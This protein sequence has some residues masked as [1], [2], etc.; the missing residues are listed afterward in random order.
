MH[1]QE[2]VSL[3]G[4]TT[5]RIGGIARWYADL[6]TR[7]DVTKAVTFAE[8]EKVPLIILGGGSNTIFADGMINALVARLACDAVIMKDNI[9]T[10]EAAKNLPMLINELAVQ[11]LDLSALTGILG[12]V[13]GAVFGNAG[14]GPKGIWID[15]YIESVT[16][17]M[18]GI[19]RTPS[20]EQCNFRYRESWFKDQLPASPAGGSTL[21]SPAF[22]KASAGRQLSTSPVIWSVTLKLPRKDPA[23]IRAE[24]E[25][26]LKKRI[27]TQPHIKTAGSCFKAVGDTPAW[28]LIDAAG[29]RDTKTGGVR[30]SEKHANFLINDGNGTFE[31]AVNVVH[32]IKSAIPQ[33][34]EVEMRFIEES[35]DTIEW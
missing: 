29:L 25:R 35:G 23:Q 5:M 3:K 1:I 21:N 26:L 11:G 19:W 24:I 31:D 34:L 30:I 2:N 28:Q 4:K 20:R 9:V 27:E 6:K 14:Q 16:A 15:S 22:A 17:L 10:V 12:T 18:N 8:E 7:E 33:A 13:G 32:T